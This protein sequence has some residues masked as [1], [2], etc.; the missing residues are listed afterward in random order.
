MGIFQRTIKRIPAFYRRF[1]WKGVS[2]I[3]RQK[4]QKKKTIPFKYPKEFLQPVYLRKGTSDFP[5]FESVLVNRC[6]DIDYKI[7]PHIIFD[8]GANIGMT[9]V[10]YATRFPQAKIISIEPETT[11]FELLKKN[12]KQYSNINIYQNGLWN[13]SATLKV[14]DNGH[15]EWGFTVKEVPNGTPGGVKAVSIPD[16]MQQQQVNHIDILKI[17]IEGAEKEL[18]DSNYQTWLP[19]VKVIVIELHDRMREG[20]AASFFKALAN[21]NYTLEIKGENLVCF[22]K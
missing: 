8:C 1:G 14:E 20:T 18:F 9:S 17:D 13:K 19:K 2:I 15:G 12:T 11:N 10:F 6:Y 5:V 7:D 21:Y 3:Y 16:L 22:L 4:L